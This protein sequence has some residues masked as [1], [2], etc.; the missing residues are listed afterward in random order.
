MTALARRLNPLAVAA[1][2]FAAAWLAFLLHTFPGVDGDGYS[3][4]FDGYLYNGLVL[5]GALLCVARAVCVRESRAAWLTLGLGLAAWCAGEIVWTLTIADLDEIPVPSAAD[6][7]YLAFYPAAYAGLVLLVRARTAILSRDL[8]LDGAIAA[9]AVAGLAAALTLE[10]VLDAGY[11]EPAEVA[12]NLAYPIGDLALLS[13]VA[14]VFGLTGWRPG[15]SWALLGVGLAIMAVADCV[16]LAQSAKGT[17]IEGRWLDAIWPASALLVGFSAW[18]GS[19]PSRPPGFI[20]QRAVLIPSACGLLALGLVG[21]GL[22]EGIGR[23]AA[24][25]AMA[26]LLLV[27]VRMALAFSENQRAMLM[28]R[29]QALTDSLTGLGNRR[30][31]MEE[32]ERDISE[33]TPVKP[34][35]CVIL[36][37]DGFKGY[38]DSYGHPAGDELL[39]RLGGRL[40]GAVAPHGR[41]YRL[42][43]DEFCVVARCSPPVL[44]SVVAAARAALS[45]AG[46]GFAVTSSAGAV[47]IPA[48]A[49]T[50]SSILQLA[51]RRMYA[52][53]DGR[54]PS[55]ARQSGDVLLTTLR[56]REPELHAHLN[57]VAELSMAVARRLGM[58]AEDLDEVSRAA[59]LHDVGKIA[60]PE[61]ILR[62]PG[63]LD[64]EE[65]S[66]MRRHTM[67]GERILSAAPAL[68][69]VA[70]IVRSSHERWDGAGY[71]DGLAGDDIPIGAR[72]V[73]V[74][75]AYDAMVSDRPYR[76]AR[77]P[78]EALAELRGCAGTQFD[79]RVVDAFEVE[80]V[81]SGRTVRRSR[82][83]PAA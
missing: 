82:S 3:T 64:D 48:E 42:G 74:C 18:G 26:T 44:E 43:G 53:K 69:P 14:V 10:P 58:L 40:A 52:Q 22:F 28:T 46:E 36:D 33:A 73:A 50:P 37:L 20:Q 11:S 21:Y 34:R 38:N 76:S 17:Y 19:G 39:T 2:A 78:R 1:T 16:Y 83:E 6:V 61:A 71:P 27:T 54:R 31:L 56:E 12:V 15:R 8:W 4:F 41:A 23:V 25:L 45:E 72:I 67:I 75:D 70:R 9:L 62:K 5:A 30:R 59:E 68:V 77:S 35:T 60:I 49:D 47:L 24:L 66:F 13:A 63:P 65:W 29:R 79:P 55:P 7:L 80:L 32:L 57:G 81:R 51:D